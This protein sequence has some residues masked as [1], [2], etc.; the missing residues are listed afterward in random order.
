MTPQKEAE[1]FATLASMSKLLEKVIATQDEHARKLDKI[2]ETQ[3]DHT[4]QIARLDGKIEMLA[5]WMQ[6]TDQRFTA[7]MA[8]YQQK[9]A[10]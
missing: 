10:A 2:Q 6:S 4:K 3:E 7:I 5:L 1:L 8:P 9:P